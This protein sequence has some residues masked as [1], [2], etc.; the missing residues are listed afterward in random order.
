[1]PTTP[2]LGEYL[3]ELEI[4]GSQHRPP[5]A[6]A[7]LLDPPEDA[8]AEYTLPRPLGEFLFLGD[9]NVHPP[10][11]RLI[12]HMVAEDTVTSQPVVWVSDKIDRFADDYTGPNPITD[13][14]VAAERYLPP[15]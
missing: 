3:D 1:M 7:V 12:Y 9:A 15:S 11:A 6:F 14:K 10:G 2:A 8:S 5:L 13:V 4:A